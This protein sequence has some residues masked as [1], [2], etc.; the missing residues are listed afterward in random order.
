MPGP[1][2]RAS[3]GLDAVTEVIDPLQMLP[4]PGQGALAVECRAS[5][6]ALAATLTAALDDSGSRAAVAAERAF[7]AAVQAGCTAPVGALADVAEDELYL[8]G[9]IAS[10]D[11]EEV[12]RQS[13]TGAISF[14]EEI[15]R[16]LAGE[17]FEA[18][19]AAVLAAPS[20]GV[21]LSRRESDHCDRDTPV[22]Q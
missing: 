3:A 19:A 13:M 4:A 15:G 16:R 6:D 8:R 1:G 20:S 18:G 7:L 11:G 14:P 17:L 5:D 9:V 12:F 21:R 2:W 10:L 22:Q